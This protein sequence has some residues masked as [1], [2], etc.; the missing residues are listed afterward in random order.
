MLHGLHA[1]GGGH[2]DDLLPARGPD[3]RDVNE[4]SR[5]FRVLPD[6]LLSGAAGHDLLLAAAG[7]VD[8]DGL[9]AADHLHGLHPARCAPRHLHHVGAQGPHLGAARRRLVDNCKN[10][11]LNTSGCTM[12]TLSC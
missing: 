5:S 1:A 9:L 6:D 8:D 2:D 3:D 11:M 12:H 7:L 10:N 4:G